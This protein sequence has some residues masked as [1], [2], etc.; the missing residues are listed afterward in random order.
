M[1]LQ[2]SEFFKEK[3]NML[4]LTLRDVA[5]S[6][7]LSFKYIK[8]IED[9]LQ[10]PTFSKL[11]SLCDALGISMHAYLRHINYSAPKRVSK[12]SKAKK[13][14]GARGGTRTPLMAAA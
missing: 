13:C 9:G 3:R 6:S 7:G 5:E 14:C 11:K 12:A 2:G 8:C 4:G 1:G 10:E